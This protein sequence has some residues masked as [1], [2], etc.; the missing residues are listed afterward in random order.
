MNLPRKR[1]RSNDAGHW[2]P[3]GGPS[4]GRI[5]HANSGP[6]EN[7]PF[8]MKIYDPSRFFLAIGSQLNKGLSK[9][10]RFAESAQCCMGHRIS[11]RRS[12]KPSF[13]TARKKSGTQSSGGSPSHW[14]VLGDFPLS[15]P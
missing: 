3:G 7:R 2:T 5:C 15:D 11:E 1:Q 14:G 12:F 10:M 4:M 9:P 6:Q 8:I 13:L